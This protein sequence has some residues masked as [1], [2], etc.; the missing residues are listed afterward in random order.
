MFKWGYM[1]PPKQAS[2]STATARLLLIVLVVL[3]AAAFILSGIRRASVEYA[4][5][6]GVEVA[7]FVF[8]DVETTTI[9]KIM[10]I[11]A[12]QKRSL[13]LIKRPGD[14]RGIDESGV[15]LPVDL[16]QMPE[17]LHVLANMRYNRAMTISERSA[18]ETFGLADGAY[19]T[20]QFEA[21]NTPYVLRI[22]TKNP[23]QSLAYAWRGVES[24][25]VLVPS[26]QA[27]TLLRLLENKAANPEATP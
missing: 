19:V 26:A 17:V 18:L 27:D 16:T 8:P 10:L 2:Q 25:I 7:P 9:T 23:D 15:I 22:G 1:T 5:T 21:L 13:T 3:M 24:E 12:D 20:V 11:A 6:A 14:W 4:P